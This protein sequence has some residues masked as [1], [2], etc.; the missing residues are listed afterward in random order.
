MPEIAA[1]ARANDLDY[2][3]LTDH[4]TLAA[5]EHGEEGWHG[6]TLLLVGSEVS[7]VP[8]E[9]LPR[10][11]AA[12]A[13]RPPRP[14]AGADRRAREAGG[15]FGF[16]AHPFSQGSERFR[17]GGQGMP[18]GDLDAE[19]YTGIELWSFVTDTRR[20]REQHPG[21]ARGSSPR[22]SGSSTTRRG[23]TSTS[24]TA[25]C[26]RRRCVAL[27]GV[28]AHQVGIRVGGRVPLRLMAYKRSF[29]YLRTHLL[30]D[31][32]ADGASW[33]RTAQRCSARCAP[34][35]RTSRW[36]R[37]RPR[38]ASASGPRGTARCAMGDEARGGD[39][40][41]ARAHC[42]LPARAAPAARRRARS[43][44]RHGDDARA[45]R[46]RPGRVPRRGLPRRPR[47]RAHLDP[48]EPDL[49]AR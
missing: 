1:A 33:T 39:M 14:D 47:A 24:G 48:V 4:D 27:G 8:P 26:A 21:A 28:D 2:L 22:R 37:S 6:S 25:S 10:V 12:R 30:V 9:P 45:P 38:R 15:G 3:L 40:D 18:W 35:T 20:A 29:R 31:R 46:R 11:R 17:R 32:A 13:D 36:T 7:P 34:V 44:P 49:P 41:A 42:P 16:P 19:G 43:R 5:A 23:A